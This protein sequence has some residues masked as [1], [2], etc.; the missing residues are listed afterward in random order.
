VNFAILPDGE[1]VTC[2][3]GLT[4]VKIHD[5]EGNFLGVVA[6]PESFKK[7]DELVNNSPYRTFGALD[8]AAGADGRILIL[9][10][11]TNEVRTFR[12]TR[13]KSAALSRG[14]P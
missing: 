9:D 2:E 1:V 11:Q 12:R 14:K 4:R 10:P 8:V 5:A 3:K 7:H 6:G 13:E